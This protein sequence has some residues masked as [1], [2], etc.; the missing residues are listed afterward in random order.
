MEWRIVDPIINM[1]LEEDLGW[2]DVTTESTIHETSISEGVFIAKETGI[3]AGIDVAE[4]VFKIVDES[5][6]FDKMAVDGEFVEKGEV[7]ATISGSS[8]SILKGERTALNLLQRMSGIATETNRYVKQVAGMKT[9]IVDTRKTMPG[10]RYLD[11]YAVRAGG[12]KNHR[13]N[14]SDLILIK[15]NHIKAAGGIKKAVEAS[16]SRLT[17]VLKIEVEVENLKMLEEAMAAGADIIMLDNMTTEMMKEAVEIVGGRVLL[18]A[19]G[20][21]SLEPNSDRF[22]R[23]VAMTGVDIIS[24]GALTHSVKSMDISLKFK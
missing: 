10:L 2:G 1:A 14:L 17:H 7:L 15:D 8:R 22:V 9:N 6:D 23:T 3:I 12:G 18:E 13:Y 16:R 4:R 19:S 11:K 21:I 24:V 5:L 20:N